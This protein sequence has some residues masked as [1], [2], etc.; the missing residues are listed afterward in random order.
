MLP[1]LNK[2]IF[3]IEDDTKNRAVVKTILEYG[4]AIVS[5]ESWGRIEVVQNRLESFLPVDLILLDLMFPKNVSGYDV[6]DALRK[7]SLFAHIP[8]VAISASDPTLEMP[9][10]RA[11]G[12]N[13]F[14]AKPINIHSFPEQIEKILTQGYYWFLG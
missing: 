6:F 9:K 7:E 14:I 8:I 1:L 11:K 10:L 12:F 2:R 3:Y 5:S 13:G 4:G